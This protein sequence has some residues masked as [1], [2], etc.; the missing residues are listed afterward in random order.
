[1]P[2]PRSR[3]TNEELKG[4]SE[5]RLMD[6]LFQSDLP[7][8]ISSRQATYELSRRQEARRNMLQLLFAGLAALSS[9][10]SAVAAIATMY[11]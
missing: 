2:E 9:V 6:M 3:Y 11:Q 10:A 8:G 4:L 5:E 1:M 7:E